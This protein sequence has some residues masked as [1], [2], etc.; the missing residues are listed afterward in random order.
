M[1][2]T[3]PHSPAALRSW[4][5]FYWYC[6]HH[7]NMASAVSPRGCLRPESHSLTLTG[8]AL[9]WRANEACRPLPSAQIARM[10]EM[11]A[12]SRGVDSS[13]LRNVTQ[14][15]NF[16]QSRNVTQNRR[17]LA[18]PVSVDFDRKNMGK[19]L[20]IREIYL[21]ILQVSRCQWGWLS[22]DPWD[23]WVLSSLGI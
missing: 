23:I 3:S 19:V 22:P 21:L 6:C 10:P 7:S 17:E 1:I 16:T 12:L 8:V 14:N 11:R 15:G 2:S 4:R 18:S 20:N 5:V 9:R 13:I